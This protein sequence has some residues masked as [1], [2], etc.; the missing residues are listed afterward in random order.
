MIEVFRRNGKCEDAIE[1][2]QYRARDTLN[3]VDEAWLTDGDKAFFYTAY[4]QLMLEINEV[5]DAENYALQA[6]DI[7]ERCGFESRN[8][9]TK[10]VLERIKSKK[11]N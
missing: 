8:Q 3:D 4:S 6:F 11:L 10:E 9:I 1:Q 5:K 7:N 2:L